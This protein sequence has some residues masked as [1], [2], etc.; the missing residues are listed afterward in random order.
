MRLDRVVEDSPSRR[1]AC[2]V[3]GRSTRKVVTSRAEEK[4]TDEEGVAC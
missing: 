3:D 1:A 2:V 4:A